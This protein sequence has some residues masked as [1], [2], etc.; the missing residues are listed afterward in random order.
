V[1]L[2]VNTTYLTRAAY[3]GFRVGQTEQAVISQLPRQLAALPLYVG[4]PPP[5]AATC[6]VFSIHPTDADSGRGLNT[7]Y[8]LCFRAGVLVEKREFP[9]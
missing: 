1:S 4:V 9:A 6:R 5:S 2:V 3:D 8:R 7:L